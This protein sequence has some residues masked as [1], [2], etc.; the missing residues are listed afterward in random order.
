MKQNEKNIL[1]RKKILDSALSEFANKGYGL[2]SVNNICADGD[3]SKGILYHYFKDKDELYLL[4]VKELFDALT[5]YL[6]EKISGEKSVQ[7]EKYF[8][9]RQQ[10]FKEN[11]LYHKLFCDVV[12][13]PP[14]H[15]ANAISDAKAPF[16]ALNIAVL[17]ELLQKEKLRADISVSSAVETFRLYQDFINARYQMQPQ[18][19]VDLERH[20]EMCKRSLSIL[21]YGV[22]R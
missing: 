13:A 11:T 5:K 19:A 21:L 17:T 8:D 22:L 3:I 14:S 1:S 12:I 10:F 2:S 15:L 9:A 18:T 20:E 4:C 7:L 6:S 16:D